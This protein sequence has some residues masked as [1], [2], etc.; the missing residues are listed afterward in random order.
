MMDG[1]THFERRAGACHVAGFLVVAVLL[2][3]LLYGSAAGQ[4]T[5]RQT[6][7][8]SPR[9]NDGRAGT[10][11]APWKTFAHAWEVL[12]PGDTLVLLDGTYTEETT[13]VL[14]PNMRNGRPG[15]PI[16]VKALHDGK[17]TIDGQQRAI[18]VK[19]GD[20]WGNG[21]PFG[22]WYVVEGIVAR[23]G[24][25]SVVAV[26]GSHNVLRRVSV[27]D[28]D[29]DDNTLNLLLMGNENLVEDCVVAGTGRYMID[30][31]GGSGNTV[32]R[33]FTM[34]QRWDGRHFCGVT[35]PNGNNI[36]IYNASGNTIEN[37]IA[38]GRSMTGIFIQANADDAV[39][40]DNRI[41]GSMALLQGRN[42]DG[43][44]WRFGAAS[45]PP[46]PRPGPTSDRFTARVCD[47]AVTDFANSTRSG[48]ALW[49]QGELRNNLFRDV[50][51]ADNMGVGISVEKPY[52]PGPRNAWFDHVTAFDN[53]AGAAP[54][55]VQGGGN[56]NLG[57][58][59]VRVTNSRIENSPW[60][61]QGEGARLQHR[62]V[63]GRLTSEPL[64]PWPMERRIAAE[65]GVSVGKIVA[66]YRDAAAAR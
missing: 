54:Y 48:F 44:V 11:V 31:F 36:G 21:G 14:Q 62:Y 22:D 1:P 16:T 27:Y 43:S 25:D 15:K 10:Q 18:P 30:I 26:K 12:R 56:I 33:C 64:L 51:A 52:G 37:A 53:G 45:W 24:L 61:A 2:A 4:G 38:Y 40:N 65:L 47:D 35:W 58:G 28:G 23:N 59:G 49:G 55:E 46:A 32:R 57:T 8:L 41:L 17:V 9:G 66:Q 29:P 39:A 20:N 13:G 50:L 5:G 63:D 3:A 60:A 19:L 34:W 6:Y 7:Y 42:Y